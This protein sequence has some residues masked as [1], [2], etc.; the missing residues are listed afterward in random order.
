VVPHLVESSAPDCEI[1][2]PCAFDGSGEPIEKSIADA[3]GAAGERMVG[4]QIAD[5]AIYNS[6]VLVPVPAISPEVQLVGI[7]RL[8]YRPHTTATSAWMRGLQEG[9]SSWVNIYNELAAERIAIAK[10]GT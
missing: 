9:A 1:L 4:Q 10:V 5:R 6:D 2:H 3:A 7:Y 8:R